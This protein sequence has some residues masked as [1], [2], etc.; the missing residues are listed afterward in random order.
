MHGAPPERHGVKSVRSNLTWG[1]I[2]P[3]G[4][5]ALAVLGIASWLAWLAALVLVLGYP[6][7]G[8]RV[9]RTHRRR[10][11]WPRDARL[12]ATFVVL[13]KL[14]QAIGQLR[15]ARNRR[16]GRRTALIEYKGATAA[17]GGG[18]AVPAAR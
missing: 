8:W 16:A 11:R 3:L 10:G 9:Y 1:L 14:P 12:Y 4:I 5:A 17:G 2:V 6:L 18:A 15:Y 13:G 7:I